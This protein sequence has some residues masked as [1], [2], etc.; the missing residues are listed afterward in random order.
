MPNFL[1]L[2]SQK[3][4]CGILVMSLYY[5]NLKRNWLLGWLWKFKLRLCT[6]T[7]NLEGTIATRYFSTL[8]TNGHLVY[9][10]FQALEA[11]S[12][13]ALWVMRMSLPCSLPTGVNS[14]SPY[15]IWT[16]FSSL[17]W[18][19]STYLMTEKASLQSSC[20]SVKLISPGE[21]L[22]LN[23]NS[24]RPLKSSTNVCQCAYVPLRPLW[25]S[26][27]AGTLHDIQ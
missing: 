12:E 15:L 21:S 1:F 6:W 24:P 5:K 10:I 18:S 17:Y 2:R 16:E 11:L 4:P 9:E 3:W 23:P 26:V 22:F 25:T 8:G 7:I 14:N 13:E 20:P 27:P 19:G